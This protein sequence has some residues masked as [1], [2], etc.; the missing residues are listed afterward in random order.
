MHLCH[1]HTPSENTKVRQTAF[2]SYPRTCQPFLISFVI[3][4]MYSLPKPT[5][6]LIFFFSLFCCSLLHNNCSEF[7]FMNSL[8]DH[9]I[10]LIPLYCYLMFVKEQSLGNPSNARGP[11]RKQLAS[12]SQLKRER[13]CVCV[14]QCAVSS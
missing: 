1:Y 10:L 13:L 6:L 9:Y 3:W 4:S 2:H 14:V 5:V 8:R 11:T 7:L 12:V